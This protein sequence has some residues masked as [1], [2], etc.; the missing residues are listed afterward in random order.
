MIRAV[1]TGSI[2]AYSGYATSPM[3]QQPF[4]APNPIQDG[5]D[6]PSSPGRIDPETLDRR[7]LIGTGELATPRW[8]TSSL[9]GH[10]R[11]PSLPSSLPQSFAGPS[12]SLIPA[13]PSGSNWAKQGSGLGLA[14]GMMDRVQEENPQTNSGRDGSANHVETPPRPA[15][16]ASRDL[17]ASR[18]APL[19]RPALSSQPSASSAAGL[20]SYVDA[21]FD[22]DIGAA[23]AATLRL[24]DDPSARLSPPP[25]LPP[26]QTSPMR[27]AQQSY[28]TALEGSSSSPG[29]T[30]AGGAS[31]GSPGSARQRIYA[32]RQERQAAALSQQNQEAMM[33]TLPPRSSSHASTPPVGTG[34]AQNAAV[35]AMRDPRKTPPARH[36][37]NASG[38]RSRPS[39]SS[40]HHEIMRHLVPRD[41]S[42]LPPSPSSASITQFLKASGSIND[43]SGTSSPGSTV[44][45]QNAVPFPLPP[46]G[47]RQNLLRTESQ[48]T[49]H[50]SVPREKDMDPETA[51]ALRKLDGLGNTPVK[52]RN[53]KPKSS[54]GPAAGS[55]RPSTPP[56]VKKHKSLAAAERPSMSEDRRKSSGS[57]KSLGASGPESPLQNWVDIMPEVPSLPP[58]PPSQSNAPAGGKQSRAPPVEPPAMDKP[59]S[60]SSTSHI[61][62]PTSRDSAPTSATTP[63]S[64]PGRQPDGGPRRASASSEASSSDGAQHLNGSYEKVGE[65]SVPPVPPLPKGYAS[66]AQGLSS[67][68]GGVAPTAYVPLRDPASDEQVGEFGTQRPPLAPS[69]PS[70]ESMRMK[71]KWSF[72]SA[73]NLKL[74]AKDKDLVPAPPATAPLPSSD[75]ETLTQQWSEVNRS[76]LLLPPEVQ[77]KESSETSSQ[78]S[79]SNH[80]VTPVSTGLAPTRS[81]REPPRKTSSSSIP[82]FRRASSSSITSKVPT[83]PSAPASIPETPDGS[84][85]QSPS[86]GP[87]PLPGRP[88]NTTRKSVLGMHLPSMLRGSGSKRGLAQQLT[89]PELPQAGPTQADLPTDLPRPPAATTGWKGRARGKVRQVHFKEFH[90]LT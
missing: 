2:D 55:S 4:L 63:S 15:R 42:H 84:P 68:A 78:A 67:V 34:P 19:S 81:V 79:R 56:S 36:S 21:M 64:W 13:S 41:F 85:Q 88:A 59:A 90:L 48:R 26:V 40:T 28:F 24:N 7:G 8:A 30:P 72:S 3:P 5:D 20:G 87:V 32:R 9:R 53:T 16:R 11:T 10:N 73:L 22:D 35:R 82:F 23:L 80:T 31:T 65:V 58:P 45:P 12:G 43:L 54:A 29:S 49:R 37:D 18:T 1:L 70:N 50:G 69:G 86:N 62:T 60:S 61:G 17:S 52:S 33:Q 14:V 89:S 46:S 6:S 47:S 38:A 39:P 51:E 71:K 27:Q 76:E 75:K 74:G 44:P 66:M 25:T 77:R 83:P 57:M